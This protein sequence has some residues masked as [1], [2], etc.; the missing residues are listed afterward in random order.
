MSIKKICSLALAAMLSSALSTGQSKQIAETVLL[1]A[2]IY[3]VNP[4]QPWAEAL[5]IRDGK[6]IAVGTD[7]EVQGYVGSSTTTLDARGHLVLP[8]FADCH[9]HFME[10][11]LGLEQVDLNG[12][13]SVPEIQKRVKQYSE[14]H[15][16]R[17]WI[18]GMG[19]QYPV[20]APSGLPT[21]KVL[22]DVIADKPVLLTA[23]DGH[24][25]WAN[26]KALELAG[27]TRD[28]PDPPNG[29]I[30]RDSNGEATGALLEH[31]GE[32]V[33]KVAPAPTR[34]DRLDA[35]RKGIHEANRVGLTRVHSAGGDFAYFD[36]YDELRKRG[37][38][39]LRFY[40]AYFLD[41][42]ELKPE[43][44]NLIEAA[45]QK[46]NNDW[47]SG[48]V[49]KTMLDGVVESHTAAMLEPYSDDPSLTGKLFWDPDKYNAAITE[50]DKRGFQVFTHAIGTKAVRTALDAYQQANE[51]NHHRDA[52]DRIEHIETITAPDIPRFG[53]LGVI[54]SMQPL[55]ADPNDDTLKIWA[56]NAGPDR[57]SRAWPWQS[58]ERGHGILAFGSDWPVVTLNPWPGVHNAVTRQTDKGDPPGGWIPNERI[59]LEDTIKAYTLNA[60]FAGHR[61]KSE[62]SLEPGKLA[63]MIVLQQDLFKIPASEISKTE[64]ILTMVGGKVAYQ[65][66]AWANTSAGMGAQQ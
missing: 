62:G 23:Y 54:A 15:P 13:D 8:G 18:L 64:V 32:L 30:V 49:V 11:A 28:T 48:G 22:D 25:N 47:L 50:L 14:A 52:R 29:K 35:L 43:Q 12:A 26:S 5:A 44:I 20:F 33:R 61:E 51:A 2:K 21:K 65:S 9:I 57:A 45:R 10:G 41:P 55:H 59:S 58:I 36:L 60:A 4:K 53:K 40:I 24:T 31:A 1:H 37:D 3:T 34:E 66:P 16:D 46:Y 27:I 38:L 39:T 63:D 56:R 42:P 7:K 6:I 17:P 19:W